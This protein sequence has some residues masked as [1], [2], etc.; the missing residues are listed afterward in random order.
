M[1]RTAHALAI[2]G[3]AMALS[4]APAFAA[5][6]PPGIAFDGVVTVVFHDPEYDNGNGIAGADVSVWVIDLATNI[7]LE[8]Y[9]GTTDTSGVASFTGVVRP[10]DPALELQVNANA[11]RVRTFV[12]ADACTV[13][14]HLQGSAAAPAGLEVTIDIEVQGQQHER[15]CP[16]Q[17]PPMI[18]EGYALTE[19]GEPLPIVHAESTL[20]T[21]D[22]LTVALPIQTAADGSFR[23]EVPAI[24]DAAAERTLTVLILG[25]DVRTAVDEEG[26][27]VT[28]T[29][30]A[31]GMWGLVGD[32]PPVSTT[33]VASEEPLSGVC[34]GETATPRPPDAPD[35]P[36]AP[37]ITLP[38]TDTIGG[39][40]SDLGGG[41]AAGLFLLLVISLSAT[42]AAERR[43][44]RRGS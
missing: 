4:A 5:E 31:L 9:S 32:E 33:L 19:D 7:V 1:H 28:W 27:L 29:L 20:D 15:S 16:P 42:I 17:G 13:T 34:G 2:L 11:S 26:C 12:D 35:A 6:P 3:A 44:S 10:I 22:G 36:D 25:P 14:E 23:V 39:G 18:V 40:F 37:N 38:P 30:V 43:V 41:L 8:E 21:P 24:G